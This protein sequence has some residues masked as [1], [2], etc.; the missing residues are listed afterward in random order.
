MFIIHIQKTQNKQ[1]FNI[2][3][4]F[5][6]RGRTRVERQST[7]NRVKRMIKNGHSLRI[8]FGGLLTFIAVLIFFIA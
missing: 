1:E 6:Q 7:G 8:C 3:S 2:T 5:I 4:Y